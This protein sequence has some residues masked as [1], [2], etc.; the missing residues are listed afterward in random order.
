MPFKS[1]AQMGAAFGGHLGPEMKAKA[2]EWAHET[3]DIKHLPRHVDRA[4]VRKSIL[5]K[6]SYNDGRD[7]YPGRKNGPVGR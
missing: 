6:M 2:R 7:A 4:K 1:K 5:K 3:P